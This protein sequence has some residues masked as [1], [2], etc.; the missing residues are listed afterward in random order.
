M[1]TAP[2]AVALLAAANV[3]LQAPIL[4]FAGQG[5]P[6]PYN[7]AQPVPAGQA[8]LQPLPPGPPPPP[9]G[10]VVSGND[11]IVLKGGGM[12]RGRILEIIPNDHATIALATGQNAIV[13]WDRIDR[14]EQQPAAPPPP[15]PPGGQVLVVAPPPPPS[16][17]A[18]SVWVHIETS[19]EVVLEGQSGSGSWAPACNSPCD[20]ELPLANSYRIAGPG[21]RTSHDFKIEAS[22]GQRVVL[23]VKTG[24]KGAFTGGIVLVSVSP[25]VV[26]IGFVV[27]LVGALDNAVTSTCT[28]GTDGDTGCSGG[29]GGGTEATGG[30]MM[31]IGAAGTVAGIVLIATNARTSYNQELLQPGAPPP[32]GKL[33][34]SDAVLA[35][36]QP[37]RHAEDAWLRA[38][39]WHEPS[40]ME[41]TLP[42][43]QLAPLFSHAF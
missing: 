33:S 16:G 15:P 39:L 38:P 19:H 26:L 12:L 9:P 36:L 37:K 21:V 1:R 23:N 8:P 41:R 18:G 7:P 13:R 42:P 40:A 22:P 32:S 27:F 6:V 25:A 43:A 20:A 4:A 14:I 35:S 3:S 30:I 34:T 31:L 28:A 5:Q 10:P 2:L 11:V 17:P 29:G 24:S